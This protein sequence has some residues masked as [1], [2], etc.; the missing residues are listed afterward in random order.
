MTLHTSTEQIPLTA[1]PPTLPPLVTMEQT[2]M[3]PHQPTALV[4]AATLPSVQQGTGIAPTP[5]R[6]LETRHR[7]VNIRE[8][9]PRITMTTTTTQIG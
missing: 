7:R 9:T 6:I 2:A 5:H 8:T 3:P 1:P 4:W